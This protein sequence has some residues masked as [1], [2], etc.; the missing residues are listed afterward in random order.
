[1]IRRTATLIKAIMISTLIGLIHFG[2][3]SASNNLNVSVNENKIAVKSSGASLNDILTSISHKSGIIFTSSQPLPDPVDCDFKTDDIDEAV[4]RLLS[5][6]K[7]SYAIFYKKDHEGK[8]IATEVEIAGASHQTKPF[9]KD[10]SGKLK[11]AASKPDAHIKQ[12]QRDWATQECRNR[13][14]LKKSILVTHNPN[15]NG[16]MVTAVEKESF[17]NTIGIFK[18]DVLKNINGTPIRSKQDLIE[19]LTPPLPAMLRIDRETEND[20]SDPIYIVLKNT[21]P[22]PK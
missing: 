4:H 6:Y 7:Y 3:V 9:G 13:K 16:V 1:M 5:K 12:M 22:V 10:R 20:L 21:I 18:G 15:N 19:Q 11:M 14:K 8:L 17:L 2:V